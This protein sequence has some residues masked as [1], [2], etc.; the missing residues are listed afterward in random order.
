MRFI[1]CTWFGEFCSCSSLT[2]LPGPAWVLLN[3]SCKELI[4]SLYKSNDSHCK[5]VNEVSDMIELIK[6]EPG[7]LACILLWASNR[8]K[9]VLACHLIRDPTCLHFNYGAVHPFR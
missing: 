8:T 5:M 1:L 4:S 9:R 3:W 7:G 6:L 2:A